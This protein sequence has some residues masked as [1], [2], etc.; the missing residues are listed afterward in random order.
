MFFTLPTDTSMVRTP[1]PTPYDAQTSEDGFTLIELLIVLVIISILMAAAF[2]MF[3]G[4]KDTANLKSA[5]TAGA[6]YSQAIERYQVDFAGKVPEGANWPND[7][8][9]FKGPVDDR[10]TP[11]RRYLTGSQIP[12]NVKVGTAGD[13]PGLTMLTV[14]GAGGR[15]TDGAEIRYVHGPQAGPGGAMRPAYR[16]EIHVTNSKHKTGFVCA[17]GDYATGMPTNIDG[18]EGKFC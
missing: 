4:S 18:V 8:D 3:G 10:L 7:A 15:T 17:Y 13:K 6:T 5:M 9:A 14:S 2:A 12:E 1:T 16:L 11:A